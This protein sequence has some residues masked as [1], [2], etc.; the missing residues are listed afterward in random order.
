MEWISVKERLP[1]P[2]QVV[3]IYWRDREV[4]LGCRT[5]EREE[6]KQC[7]STEGW[8]SFEDEKCK[9]TNWWM[10]INASSFD[11]PSPPQNVK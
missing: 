9:W 7:D 6:E 1:D 3:W 5:Y 8:Y 2:W 10:Q 11:K 4:L